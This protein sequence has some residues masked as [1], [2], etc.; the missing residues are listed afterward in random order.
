MRL[1]D[2][3]AELEKLDP[4]MEVIISTEYP[5]LIEGREWYALDPEYVSVVDVVAQRDEQGV[6]RFTFEKSDLSRRI[7]IINATP[8]M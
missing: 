5:V 1:G 3:V 8:E 6:V 2:L 7:A 4:E